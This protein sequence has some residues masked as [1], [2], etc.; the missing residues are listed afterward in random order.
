M[1]KTLA[2][3]TILLASSFIFATE[4]IVSYTTGQAFYEIRNGEWQPLEKDQ[5]VNDNTIVKTSIKSEIGL[6][7]KNEIIKI[8]AMKKDTIQNLITEIYSG[9]TNKIRK[10]GD[11]Q[12][13]NINTS[14][15]KKQ[16]KRISTAASR[17]EGQEE[18]L[19]LEENE[20]YINYEDYEDYE[21]YDKYESFE[22]YL[23]N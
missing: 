17:A 1:K 10:S 22:D 6:V 12:I 11:L 2:L 16:K 9:K 18:E 8:P 7:Y 13:N 21:D 19:N 15:A 5:I 4:Y 3:L 23:E 20:E 14:E